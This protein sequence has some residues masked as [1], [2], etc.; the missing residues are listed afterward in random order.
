MKNN[1]AVVYLPNVGKTMLFKEL[2][3]N[4]V[5]YTAFFKILSTKY[6]VDFELALE[7]AHDAKRILIELI[8]NGHYREATKVVRR[9]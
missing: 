6:R 5:E 1:S 4:V 8:D 2:K 9:G 7:D 3:G